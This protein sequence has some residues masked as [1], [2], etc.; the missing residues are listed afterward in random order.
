M[1]RR[2]ATTVAIAG[3]LALAACTGDG[4]DDAASIGTPAI[5]ATEASTVVSALVTAASRSQADASAAGVAARA[6]IYEGPALKAADARAK[7]LAAGSAAQRTDAQIGTDVTVLGVSAKSDAPATILARASLKKSNAP[8]LVLLVGGQG[9]KDVRIAAMAPMIADATLDA[10]DP[11]S[12]GSAGLGS[13]AGLVAKPADVSAA[14]AASVAFPSPKPSKLI[15]ADPWSDG[16]RKDAAAQSKA[17][18]AQGVFAQSHEPTDILGGLRLKGGS[19]AVVFAHLERTDAIAFHKPT[20]QTP[21]KDV[22]VLSGIKTITTEAE[23]TSSEFIA[24]VVPASGQVRVVAA[25]D[26]LIG[27]KAH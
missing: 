17:L 18:G 26:Q 10:L 11:P 3:V 20:K 22:T 9:G 12:A 27:A 8:V 25:Q 15:A 21:R 6:G 5:A 23:L 14:W 4:A 24:F 19:G 13:G 7:V 2:A 1:T 16:L